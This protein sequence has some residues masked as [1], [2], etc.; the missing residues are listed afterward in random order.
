MVMVFEDISS[1]IHALEKAGHKQRVVPFRP[2][3]PKYLRQFSGAGLLS[4][5]TSPAR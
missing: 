1:G 5:V 4:R 3:V 2:P